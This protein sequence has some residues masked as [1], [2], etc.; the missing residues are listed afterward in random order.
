MLG[1]LWQRKFNKYKQLAQPVIWASPSLNNRAILLA[2]ITPT[3]GDR[4]ARDRSGL[5]NAPRDNHGNTRRGDPEAVT[6]I[7][8]DKSIVEK[9]EGTI[10]TKTDEMTMAIVA[11]R[12]TEIT[13]WHTI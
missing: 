12:Y 7:T 10:V 13:A 2:K 11:G 3:A 1:A 8:L 6:A 9:I 5:V 4:K